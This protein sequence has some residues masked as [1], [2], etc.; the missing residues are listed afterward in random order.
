MTKVGT[1]RA[2]RSRSVQAGRTLVELMISL[3][4]GLVIVGAIMAIYLST[5]GTSKQSNAVTRMSEDAAIAMS[6]IGSNLR[7]DAYSPPR[8]L[9]SPGSAKVGGVQVA[10]ADRNFTGLAIRGCD[11]GFADVTAGFGSLACATSGTGKGALAIR[12]EGDARNTL[13]VSGGPSDCGATAITT[14]ATSAVDASAYKLVESRLLVA[15]GGSGS[16][17]LHCA[18]NGGDSAVQFATKPLLQNVEGMYLSYGIAATDQDYEASRYVSQT[19]LDA[20]A[21][22][23]ASKWGRV[24]SVKVCLVM[25]SQ[26]TMKEADQT[27]VG[28]DGSSVAASDGYARRAFTSVFTLRNRSDFAS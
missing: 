9:V 18:G 15:T 26:N 12:F 5:A 20:F 23:T 4:I 14:D 19:T 10:A 7:M 1:R 8:V 2:L 13:A 6:L 25:K 11:N 22:S 16:S 3:V 28:C 27:Y 24:V 21:G 17:E